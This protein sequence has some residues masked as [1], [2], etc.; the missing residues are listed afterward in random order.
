MGSLLLSLLVGFGEDWVKILLSR[1]CLEESHLPAL[2]QYLNDDFDKLEDHESRNIHFTGDQAFLLRIVSEILNERL[3][4]IHVGSEFALYILGLFKNA[5]K[6]IDFYTKGQSKLPTG[7]PSIDVLGYSL[8]LLRDVCA[9]GSATVS[10]ENEILDVVASLVSRGLLDLLLSLLNELEL[11]TSIRKTMKPDMNQVPSSHSP[12]MCPYQGFRRD[13]VAVIGNCL[14]RRKNVQDEVRKK[15]CI[16]LLLQQCVLDDD[17]PFLREW[18]IWCAS[19][20]LQ[21]ND[22]N[23]QIVADM[24]MQGT[25]EVPELA[26]L[27]L[28]VKIDPNTRHATLVNMTGAALA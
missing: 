16:F 28:Q 20:L 2:F 11:P 26:K 4:D 10:E 18:G 1:I 3:E 7:V 17:N 12:K 21:G 6:A 14:Y 15:N 13:I 9:Q 5:I 25:V 23:K 22:D 19:N 8:I 27:G 24:E